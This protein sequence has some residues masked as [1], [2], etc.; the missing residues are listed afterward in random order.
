MFPAV[1]PKP[2]DDQLLKSK[3]ASLGDYQ[4][5]PT[6]VTTSTLSALCQL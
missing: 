1:T 3:Y 6:N 2:S 4:R 5:P